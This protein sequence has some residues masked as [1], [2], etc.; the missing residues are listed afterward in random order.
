MPDRDL[1]Q[2]KVSKVIP[3]PRWSVIRLLTRV[4]E[5]PFFVPTVK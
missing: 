2:I 5:F 4:A 1:L 3:A